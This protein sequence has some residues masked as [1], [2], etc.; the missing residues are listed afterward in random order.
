M[1]TAIM[2]TLALVALVALA[3]CKGI[4][5]SNMDTGGYSTPAGISHMDSHSPDAADDKW[6]KDYYGSGHGWGWDQGKTADP[7]CGFYNSCES[8]SATGW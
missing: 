5:L 6:L 4:G 7:N 1:D 8:K 3:G 2:R